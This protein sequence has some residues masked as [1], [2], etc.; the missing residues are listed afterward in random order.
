[1]YS[2]HNSLLLKEGWCGDVNLITLITDTDN[3]Q[4]E[5]LQIPKALVPDLYFCEAGIVYPVRCRFDQ[6]L[7][8]DCVGARGAHN[9]R[10][11]S[12]APSPINWDAVY[13]QK[14]CT[15]GNH[16]YLTLEANDTD[17]EEMSTGVWCFDPEGEG[18]RIVR[19]SAKVP[20]F[21][22]A[23]PDRLC[24]IGNRAYTITVDGYMVWFH[25]ET[26]WGGPEALVNHKYLAL[27]GMV[28]VGHLILITTSDRVTAHSPY[29]WYVFDTI[30]GEIGRLADETFVCGK[31]LF[32][33]ALALV[34][35][36]GSD[37]ELHFIDPSLEYP[38]PDLRWGII[39]PGEVVTGDED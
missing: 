7:P 8:L 21:H 30:S 14:V 15:L 2:G 28:P 34:P 11:Q 35:T 18:Q 27:V 39:P 1:M 5:S 12:I 17:K 6:T 29:P 4:V 37:P 19:H 10:H 25:P 22:Y 38:H 32:Y 23:C 13:V 33:P 36:V 26:G 20:E 9:T 31:Y 24:V 16:C 3:L